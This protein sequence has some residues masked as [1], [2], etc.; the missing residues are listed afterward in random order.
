MLE[1]QLEEISVRIPESQG[2]L[3]RRR[4]EPRR[5]KCAAAVPG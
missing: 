2:F 4:M 5:P 3:T 1:G